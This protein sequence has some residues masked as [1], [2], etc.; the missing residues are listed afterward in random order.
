MEKPQYI[1]LEES[2]ILWALK[3]LHVFLKFHIRV[4]D[5]IHYQVEEAFK[6]SQWFAWN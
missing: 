6:K 4:H 1:Q 5:S 2:Q 3:V